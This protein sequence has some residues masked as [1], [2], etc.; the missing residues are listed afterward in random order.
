MPITQEQARIEL[1][2][3]ELARRSLSNIE[4]NKTQ[5]VIDKITNYVFPKWMTEAK[6]EQDKYN[7][8][9]DI[10]ERVPGFIRGAY[11]EDKSA[12]QGFLKPSTI[13]SMGQYLY[14]KE[15]IQPTG[16]KVLDFARAFPASFIG[17]AIDMA[18]NPFTYIGGAMAK[19]KGLHKEFGK[20]TAKAGQ[21]V[22]S[23]SS[24]IKPV[25]RGKDIAEFLPQT[26]NKALGLTRSTGKE[27]S[28]VAKGMRNV[29]LTFGT[30]TRNFKKFIAR[31]QYDEDAL[32]NLPLRDQVTAQAQLAKGKTLLRGQELLQKEG[33]IGGKIGRTKETKMTFQQFGQ[34]VKQDI[35]TKRKLLGKQKQSDFALQKINDR[36]ARLTIQDNLKILDS[37]LDRVSQQGAEDIQPLLK[38]FF[39]ANSSAYGERL[40]KYSEVL[41]N[42]NKP[43][44]IETAFGILDDTTKELDEMN[45]VTGKGRRLLNQLKAKYEI[46]NSEGEVTKNLSDKID[47]KE[48]NKE[49][50]DIMRSMSTTSK[51]G[52]R[53]TEDD[54]AQIVLHDKYGNYIA[55]NVP[56]FKELQ[57]AYRPV[58]NGMK[59][60]GKVFKPYASEYQKTAGAGF[61]KK[62]ATGELVPQE[63]RTLQFL[64]EGTEFA[65]GVGGISG[66]AKEV[67]GKL[68]SQKSALEQ[69][70]ITQRSNLDDMMKRFSEQVNALDEGE[71]EVNKLLA[72]RSF[73]L[74]NQIDELEKG[75]MTVDKMIELNRF[76][77]ELRQLQ[78]TE[79]KMRIEKLVHIKRK[80]MIIKAAIA[81]G[82]S[83]P[84]GIPQTIGRWAIRSALGD[85]AANK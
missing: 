29:R 62:A 37:E 14:L 40:E 42:S 39:R 85:T 8:W 26:V 76:N 72:E 6:F 15:D 60:A 43:L 78:L 19:S 44:T 67:G 71:L 2:H 34:A 38:D 48:F 80:A 9:G 52:I 79:R 32:R 64:E 11:Q 18:S 70:K 41:G 13:P 7:L 30:P 46:Y 65:Q 33:V 5:T 54:L 81:G 74:T 23:V 59:E 45:I 28:L 84:V 68:L 36:G 12:I 69:L 55:Q 17:E 51:S 57:Q 77:G 21:M 27:V 82:L 56:A 50:R 75:K 61:L 25:I 47:F 58:I 73:E 24:F 10:G 49:I 63:A 66:K 3:R 1:A 4:T 35:S 83:F 22:S 20:A 53:I 31:Q 16:N